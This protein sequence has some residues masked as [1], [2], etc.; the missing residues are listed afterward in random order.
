M[1]QYTKNILEFITDKVEKYSFI[2]SEENN[3]KLHPIY[4]LSDY[5]KTGKQ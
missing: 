1:A 2:N 4:E 3:L 5:I